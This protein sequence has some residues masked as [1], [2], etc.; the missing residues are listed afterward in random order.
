MTVPMTDR[1]SD[2][3]CQEHWPAEDTC[4]HPLIAVAGR[5][6]AC[7]QCGKAWRDPDCEHHWFNYKGTAACSGCGLRCPH[8]CQVGVDDTPLRDP[9]TADLYRH[10]RIPDE[11]G[12]EA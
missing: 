2:P 7:T 1:C 9:A 5:T 10:L 3:T 6:S 8:D 4:E 11:M 12:D